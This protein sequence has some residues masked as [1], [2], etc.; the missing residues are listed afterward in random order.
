MTITVGI[1]LFDDVEELDLAGPWEVFTL[2]AEVGADLKT[3]TI[4]EAVRVIRCVHG[5]RVIAD[6]GFA[7]APKLDVLLVPGGMGTRREVGNP[8]MLDWIRRTAAGCTWVTGVCTGS[9]L[10]AGAG[11]VRGRR[12]TTHWAFADQLDSLG[13][14]KVIRNARYIADGNLV[15][16]AGVSAGIDMSIWLVGQIFGD[17]L[18]RTAQKVMEY[19]PEPPY[20]VRGWVPKGV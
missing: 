7:D 8:V 3:V 4:A 18:A 14:G 15:T 10:L 1:L 13:E 17:E 12:Y 11:V 6:H 5:L 9:L 16:A 19:E 20:D 2:A